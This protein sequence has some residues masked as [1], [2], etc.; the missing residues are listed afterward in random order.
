MSQSKKGAFDLLAKFGLNLDDQEVNFSKIFGR[1]APVNL[2]IGFG[3][4]ESLVT[5]AANNPNEDFIGI[6]VYRSGVSSLMEKVAAFNLTNV[7][8]YYADAVEVLRCC[9]PDNSID[10]ILIFF[11]DPWPKRRHHKRRIIQ[12]E[13]IELVRIKLKNK[14]CLHLAT[15]WQEYAQHML[16][17]LSLFSEFHNI[18]Q[19]GNFSPRPHYR[20]VTKFERRGEKLDHKT[21]ELIYTLNKV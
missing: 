17:V 3:V 10:K 7:R 16:Q 14:G 12:K 4:G 1:Q 9:I 5:M 2:E 8:V 11:P 6:E 18:A 20:P 19:D 21:W 13:F 15:D